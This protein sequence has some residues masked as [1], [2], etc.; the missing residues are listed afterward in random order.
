MDGACVR[1]SAAGER[2]SGIYLSYYLSGIVMCSQLLKSLVIASEKAANIARVVRQ[3]EHLFELLVQ[4]KVGE[5]AN[6]RFVRDFKTLADVL[7]QEM[8]RH[9]LGA[10][11]SGGGPMKY[12]HYM[13]GHQLEDIDFYAAAV[14]SPQLN[15]CLVSFRFVSLSVS[16]SL[17]LCSFCSILLCINEPTMDSDR[18]PK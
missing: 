3:N 8:V 2:R 5:S 11:V 14:R 6:S 1:E 13:N 9:D 18:L 10:L 7:I 16:F 4:E 12:Y 15:V 17:F